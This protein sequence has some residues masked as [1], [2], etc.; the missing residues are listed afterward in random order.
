MR[1]RAQCLTRLPGLVVL[2]SV[3]ALGCGGGD[4]MPKTHPLKGKVVFKGGRPVSGGSIAFEC[5]IGAALWRAGSGL[6]PDGTF[7]N[8]ITFGQTAR[9]RKASLRASIG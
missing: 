3:G 2:L 5:T 8:V 6:A 4:R 9:R 7:E 1:C